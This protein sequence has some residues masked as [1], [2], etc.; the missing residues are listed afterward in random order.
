MVLGGAGKQ[1]RKRLAVLRI[2]FEA[3]KDNVMQLCHPYPIGVCYKLNRNWKNT[4]LFAD[5]K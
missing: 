1:E 5:L 2:L 4:A 3:G